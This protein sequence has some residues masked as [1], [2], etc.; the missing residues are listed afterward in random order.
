MKI[1]LRINNRIHKDLKKLFLDILNVNDN[2]RVIFLGIIASFLIFYGLGNES[3]YDW[4]EAIYAQISKEMVLNNNYL[5]L[6]YGY[7]PWFEK[8]PLLM[9]ITA[10]FFK[11]FGISE[12][13]A[14]AVSAFSGVGLIFI[15]YLVGKFIFNRNI[16]FIASLILIFSNEFLR[17]ARMGT[18]DT[19]L[20]FL[21]FLAIYGYLRLTTKEQKWWYLIWISFALAFMLKSWAAIIMLPIFA[22][23]IFLDNHVYDTLHSKHFWRGILL[24]CLLV[25]PWHIIMIAKYGM[26]FIDDYFLYHAIKRTT[27]GIE[28]H[29]EGPLYY[30]KMMRGLF[31]PWIYL[32][33]FA[34]ALS[35]KK[36]IEDNQDIVFY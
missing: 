31:W 7:K 29:H 15:V 10:L 26:E 14:R 13:W 9:C 5:T 24:A 11:C 30:I 28:T 21:F 35:I 17:R 22:F 23:A 2:W 18:T 27:T 3:L 32:V 33:P 4:D 1:I 19:M 34:I 36:N 6:Y 8:P 20:C 12:F 25:L 16:G